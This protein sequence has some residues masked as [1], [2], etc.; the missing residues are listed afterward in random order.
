MKATIKK[1]TTLLPIAVVI[2]LTVFLSSPAASAV[3]QLKTPVLKAP[4]STVSGVKVS[5]NK[6]SGAAKYRIFVKT[7][8]SSWKKLADTTATSYL[9][10]AVKSGVSYTYTVRC[11][12]KD[13]KRYTS[14]FNRKGKTIIFVKAPTISSFVNTARGP[15]LSWSACKGAAKYRIYISTASGWKKLATVST[16]NYLHLAARNNTTYAYRIQC[17]NRSGYPAS[18]TIAKVFRNYY[19]YTLPSGKITNIMFA[20][21]VYRALGKNVRIPAKPNAALNRKTAASILCPALGY[22]SRAAYVSLKDTDSAAMKTLAFYGYFYPDDTDKIYPAALVTADEYRSLLSEVGNYKK[23]H[24]KRAL[25]FGDSIMY[26]MGNNNYGFGRM[27]AEKYGMS[28]NASYASNGATFSTINNG[29]VH[30][31]DRIKSAITADCKADVIFLSGGTNDIKLSALSSEPDSFDF[32][33][34]EK[35]NFALGFHQA[36]KLIKGKWGNTPV[37]Y[38]R[39]HNMS[40]CQD[41]YEIAMGE[42]G[43]RIARNYRAYTVDLFT[44]T[45]FNTSNA[46]LRDR[47]TMYRTELGR[48]DGTHPTYLGYTTYYLPLFS[49]QLTALSL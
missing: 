31:V 36:M 1:L 29:R 14:S 49:Q 10:R 3:G 45:T 28:Y 26:G 41:T 21:D 32:D 6:V 38:V 12:S 18:A 15:I 19:S 4:V 39:A 13:G 8:S 7:G 43:L 44:N 16:T 47:Y 27:T 37:I 20:A 35:S 25:A 17:L 22:T 9:H 23:L 46:A 5:W 24:G 42:Y 11:I 2:L 48:H 30:I 34:P 33:H 40:A